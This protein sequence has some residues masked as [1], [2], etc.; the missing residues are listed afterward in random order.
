MNISTLPEYYRKQIEKKCV[1]SFEKDICEDYKKTKNCRKTAKNYNIGHDKVLRILKESGIE[2][3]IKIWSNEDIDTLKNYYEL[4][5]TETFDINDI[6]NKLNR[7]YASVA[8]MASRLQ[9]CNK[10]RG[11]S[12]KTKKIMSEKTI[13]KEHQIKMTNSYLERIKTIGHPK[14][15]AGNKH[16]D[17]TKSIISEKAKIK[18]QEKG[19][20][21]NS[22]E[23]KNNLA[24]R[25][26]QDWQRDKNRKTYSRGKGGTR[27]DL[28]MYLRSSWE[29]NYARYLN[30]IVLNGQIKKWE[31]EVDTFVFHKIK[32]G[33]MSYLPDFKVFNNDGTI[34]YHEVKGWFDNKS[35]TK[36]SRMG[37]YYPEIKIV[38]IA[39]KEYQIIKKELSSV[40]KNWE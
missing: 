10:S 37:K 20:V 26:S 38:L 21:L 16:T 28:G 13:T 25:V 9:L 33:C 24:L 34:E 3:S 23:Y 18:W 14:G 4:E 30:F 17:K 15:N 6:A 35:K 8:L 2:L 5:P 31:Y 27:A 36:L 12:D 7:S 22:E 39:K 29:A 11:K 1:A 32:R 19:Y 40:I